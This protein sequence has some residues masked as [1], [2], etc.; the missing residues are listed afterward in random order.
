MEL[1][2]NLR[3]IFSQLSA[4]I[5]NQNNNQS[6]L[7][8]IQKAIDNFDLRNFQYEQSDILEKINKRTD[9][10]DELLLIVVSG[11]KFIEKYKTIA[12]ADDY[13]TK[14]S[15]LRKAVNF[16]LVSIQKLNESIHKII[17]LDMVEFDVNY[18]KLGC[19]NHIIISFYN[20][21]LPGFFEKITKEL[22]LGANRINNLSA[23]P[24]KN[25]DTV[26]LEEFNRLILYH[27][28]QLENSDLLNIFK[29]DSVFRKILNPQKN[30]YY[31]NQISE[32]LK[33]ETEMNSKWQKK[34]NFVLNEFCAAQVDLIKLLHP[35]FMI[36]SLKDSL[37][38]TSY[39]SSESDYR[40]KYL[41]RRVKSFG[42]FEFEKKSKPLKG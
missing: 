32:G 39:I 2:T 10:I 35:S 22:R 28:P 7:E 26:F 18:L 16:D 14:D 42:L 40:S 9:S 34:P 21:L 11:M 31:E 38:M 24:K 19:V 30:K 36:T 1:D 15:Y 17:K 25:F 5:K 3:Y 4:S 20:A 37:N 41:N 6:N 29:Y 12:F 23:A 13:L 8:L 33:T 27:F